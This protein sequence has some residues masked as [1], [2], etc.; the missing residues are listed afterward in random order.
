MGQP[1]FFVIPHTH[2]EGAVFK[3]RE[4]YLQLGLPHIVQAL[5]LLKANPDYRFVLDQACYVRPFLQRY[6]QEAAAL[7]ELVA[8]GRLA[9]VG[10]TD[11]MLDVN[12][13]GGESFVRQVLYSKGYFRRAL[14]LD[15]TVGWQLD[16]FGHHAQMP[17]LLKLAGYASFWFF[18][19]VPDMDRPSEFWWEGLDGTRVAAFWLPHGYCNVYDSPKTAAEFAAYVQQRYESLAPF[20]RGA[21]RVGLAGADVSPAEEHLPRM[22]AQFN[23]RPDAPFALRF[24]VPADYEAAV[25]AEGRDRPVWRGELNPIFQGT[26]SS[27]IELKQRTRELE[28]LLTTAEKLGVIDRWLG[29][30]ADDETLW[31]AWEP[32]LFNQAHDLMSGVM[33]D[34][35]YEDVVRGYDF[36]QRLAEEELEARLHSVEGKID[37]RGDGEAL[38]VWNTLS[39]PR[40]DIVTASVGFTDA[41][42][43]AV[44]VVGP[45]GATVPVQV[46]AT[47]CHDDGTWFQAELAFLARDVPA[48][49][50]SVYRVVPSQTDES[51]DANRLAAGLAPRAD[52]MENEHYRLALD[53]R[54]GAITSLLLKSVGAAG[55]WE[56]LSAPANVV[57]R[58]ADRGDLWE[59]YRSLDGG[60][61]VA[62]KDR[63]PAPR[64]GEAVFSTD[65]PAEPA[66]AGTVTRGSVMSEFTVRHPFGDKGAFSTRIRF[67]AGLPRIDIRTTI[68]NQDQFVRYRALFPTSIRQGRSTHEIPFGAIDR[69]EGIEFPAQNWADYSGRAGG[70]VDSVDDM[71]NMDGRAARHGLAVLNRGLP[72]NNVADGTMMLSLLRSTCI[73][74]YGFFGGYEEGMSS[75]TGFEQGKELAFDYALLPHAGDWR[76]AQVYRAGLEFNHPL[77]A[78]PAAPHVGVLPSRWGLLRIN[79]PNVV[80]SALKAGPAGS[81]I[82]RLY[83][84]AGQPAPGTRIEFSAPV[85]AVEEVNLM[86]DPGQAL[87]PAASGDA[88]AVQLDLQPFGIKTVKLM[89]QGG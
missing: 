23:A 66:A 87:E 30:S 52:V 59:P 9:I 44:N 49:G 17:Q 77:L 58:Q 82:L 88:N 62:M 4:E 29:G 27:R 74:A 45:D 42:V 71:D 53:P 65:Q 43:R 70:E 69:P 85:L 13:P 51:P 56:A 47:R 48:M 46:L 31:R 33:T 67:Y 57:A 81:A 64:P 10:G 16:T 60:S 68:L 21:A 36:S 83:E 89:L 25:A 32:M 78:R 11:V 40:T 26:Y 34:H 18:R 50:Y 28:R 19:G 14:G 39:W 35:V 73:V 7:S 63:H 37:T 54:T 12:M 38:V 72:G 84:A 61:R 86:E 80:V 24:A 8:A 15:V 55:G 41:V 76:A 79:R 1:T 22:V 2:W 20:A 5:A 75:A 6:P 3:T